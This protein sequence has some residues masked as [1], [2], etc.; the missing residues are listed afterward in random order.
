MYSTCLFCTGSLGSNETIEHFPIGRRLAF[1]AAKGRLWAVCQHC[2]RWNLSPL[3]E[4]WEAI[5]QAERAFRG[6]LVRVSTDNIGLARMRDGMELIRVG[7]PLRPEFAAWR[8]GRHF[9]T[10]RRKTQYIAGAGVVA[11]AAAAVTL[12][13]MLAPA[14]GL[15]ALSIVVIPGLTT[16]M[17]AVPIVGMLAARDYIQHDRVVARLASDRRIVTVRAKHLGDVELRVNGHD[18]PASL[19][20]QHDHG[21]T[22]FTDT[23][24]MHATGVLI[25]GANKYGADATRVNDAVRQIEAAGDAGGFLSAASSRNGW[26]S[27]KIMSL[28]NQYRQLGAM[29]L[30][31]TERLALEM[32]VHEETERRAMEGELKVLEAAWR[33]A[34]EIAAISDDQLTPP[35]LYEG[36]TRF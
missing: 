28:V 12:G 14:L 31:S 25:A 18:G 24:A 15:G 1:D 16:V 36:D 27:G 5:E 3:E 2:G 20:V 7:A 11:G 6:T 21:W 29:K 17:G 26:R 4:R 22:E 23:A 33:D 9:G 10:R 19:V 32:A 30:S 34:E 13:P 8:Y 35:K